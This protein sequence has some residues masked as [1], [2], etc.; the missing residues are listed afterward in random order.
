V[1]ARRR[2]EAI[3]FDF[4]ELIT[5]LSLRMERSFAIHY[6]DSAHPDPN[7]SGFGTG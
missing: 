1:P 4:M 3:G 2:F 7:S 6:T 5:A